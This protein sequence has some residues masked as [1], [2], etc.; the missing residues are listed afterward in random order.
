MSSRRAVVVFAA[1]VA[2]MFP[3]ASLQ[4]QA[5]PSAEKLV[6]NIA[7]EPTADD[8]HE[9][10]G[11]V[12]YGQSQLAGETKWGTRSA[13]VDWACSFVSTN[14]VGPAHD[15]VTITRSDG[16]VLALAVNGKIANDTLRGKVDVIGGSGAY[17]GA[18]GAGTVIGR[19]GEATISVT[20][21]KGAGSRSAPL[22]KS[23]VGC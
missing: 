7:L 6:F 11:G 5:Q 18:R 1:I 14:G 12:N 10:P 13:K 21:S 19:T 2:T 20:V 22:T 9:L 16:V 8:V 23:G 15:L 17:R 4:A 3:I